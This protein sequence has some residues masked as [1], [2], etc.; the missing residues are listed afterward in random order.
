MHSPHALINTQEAALRLGIA[1]RTLYGW[2]QRGLLAGVL[3]PSEPPSIGGGGRR[4]GP[5][6]GAASGPRWFGTP[7]GGGFRGGRGATRM[8]ESGLT[9]RRKP[10][11]Q[12]RRI[13]RAPTPEQTEQIAEVL[14]RILNRPSAQARPGLLTGRVIQKR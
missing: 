11:L 12:V 1:H 13:Y 9:D 10:V 4:G 7:P 3:G 8:S 14:F 6:A 2:V 5:Q